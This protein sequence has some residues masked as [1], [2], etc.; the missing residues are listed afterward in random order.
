MA[1]ININTLVLIVILLFIF[2]NNNAGDGVTSQYQYNQL[3]KVKEQ[4]QI[5]YEQFNEMTINDNFKNITG[6]KLAYEDVL[7]DPP[8]NATYPLPGKNYEEWHHNQNFMILPDEVTNIIKEEVWNDTFYEARH[9]FFPD[10]ITSII[11]GEIERLST[12]FSPIRMPIAKFFQSIRYAENNTEDMPPEGD[13]YFKTRDAITNM[14]YDS[15]KISI[16]ISP[17]DLVSNSFNGPPSH[18]FNSQSDRWKMISAT[19]QFNDENETQKVLFGGL[20]I[21]DIFRGRILLMS[22]SAKFSSLFAFPHYMEYF[23]NAGD[24]LNKEVFEEVKKLITEYW[25][26]K[27]Y[28]DIQTMDH[29]NIAFDNAIER[30]EYMAFLQLEPWKGYSKSDLNIIEDELKWPMGRPANLSKLPPVRIRNGQVYA[31]D[32]GFSFS[33]KNGFGTRYELLVK[34]IRNHVLIG[35][36]LYIC[37]ILLLMRQMQHTNTPSIINKLSYSTF[38]TITLIDGSLAILYFVTANAYPELYL[39]LVASAFV[40]YV[41]STIFELRYIVSIFASQ[42]NEVGIGITTL[43]RRGNNGDSNEETRRN[44]IIPDEAAISNDHLVKFLIAMLFAMSFIFISSSWSRPLRNWSEYITIFVLNSYWIPQI[45]RNCVKGLPSRR[46]RR[47]VLPVLNRR[48]AVKWPLL[49]QF[50]LG[51][52]FIRC[53]PIIYLFSY[54]ANVFRHEKNHKIVI[55]LILWLVIQTGILYSQDILGSRWFLPK[56]AIPEEYSYH[57]AISQQ[58]LMEH[59]GSVDHTVDCSICMTEFPVYVEEIPETHKV[60][61]ESYMVTPCDHMFHTPCLESWMNYKLQCPVCRSPLPP[62]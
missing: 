11:N 54:S 40:T 59:G 32:C 58:H 42:V 5:E 1:E 27:N 6:F 34:T 35:V 18:P 28:I 23:N 22:S 12:V 61:K 55:L 52:T 10:N 62:L 37:Q 50:I 3:Q 19:V 16:S 46:E 60:D 29:I 7:Q 51:T 24:E 47:R 48:R 30:C 14:T 57:R 9:E 13:L 25:E 56:H 33:V 17:L 21:Y 4:Y 53:I 8:I 15:G 2:S 36:C 45:V 20:G 44:V 39:P 43:F 26:T 31:P 38:F 41:L 49:W